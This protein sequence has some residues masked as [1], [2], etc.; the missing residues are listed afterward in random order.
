MKITTTHSDSGLKSIF[1]KVWSIC[2]YGKSVSSS[3]TDSADESSDMTMT[4]QLVNSKITSLDTL[5]TK[6]K[7]VM[8]EMRSV[9]LFYRHLSDVST[10]ICG[11]YSSLMSQHPPFV[12][13]TSRMSS[14]VRHARRMPVAHAGTK[15]TR[16]LPLTRT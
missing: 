5:T 4:L 10:Y 15:V 3:K 8:S 6:A 2:E 7:L 11:Y 1:W 16:S 14:V 12:N 13:A 9:C